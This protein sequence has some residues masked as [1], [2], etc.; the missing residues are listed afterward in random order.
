MNGKKTQAFVALVASSFLL[1]ACSGG[2]DTGTNGAGGAG[3][4]ADTVLKVTTGQGAIPQLDPGLATFQW[5]RVLYPLLWSGLTEIDEADE[6][7]E[8]LAES[9]SANE[10]FN[11]WTFQL[12]EDVTFSNGRELTAKD[13]VWNAERAISDSNASLAH[14]YLS[15]VE[16]ITAVNDTEVRFS[17]KKPDSVLP[18]GLS[19]LRVIAP[20]SEKNINQEPIGTGPYVVEEFV[21]DQKLVLSSNED[22]WGEEP[23]VGGIEISTTNDTAAAV[24][25]LRS[26]DVDV[27]WNLPTSE[28]E[29]LEGTGNVNL[30]TASQSTQLHYLSVDT[31]T[32]PFDNVKARQALSLAW[33]REEAVNVAYSG[34]G[35]PAIY[36]ELVPKDSWALN[37]DNLKKQDNN[38]ELAAQLF[39]E[40][41][42]DKGD[43]LVWWGISGAYPEWTS[44]AQLLQEKLAKIDIKLDIKNQETGA[45]VDKFIPIGKKYP[46]HIIPN[47]GGDVSDPAFIYSR[48][49]NGACECNWANKDFDELFGQGLQTDDQDERAEI[50]GTM[51]EIVTAELPIIVSL[52]APMITATQA[53]IDGV[54]VSPPGDLHLENALVGSGSE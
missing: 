6:V 19:T 28:S 25:A 11:E 36:N 54:W 32:P 17:L 10:T 5:E 22:Y 9:W 33:D 20:E 53:S 12:R 52:H 39:E 14:T 35:E 41:G 23:D 50:Y 38:L 13:I 48:L 15:A 2:S 18:R 40:A 21:P 37:P 8:G 43:S 30:L 46:G 51:Q 31:T 1:A 44:E 27:L 45:W 26:G 42:V 4:A 47:A 34:F 29:S 3:Q 16:K 24:T 49:A 7:V